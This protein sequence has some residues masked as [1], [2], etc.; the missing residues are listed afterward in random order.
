MT[1]LFS[2]EHYLAVAEAF[3]RGIERR[4]DAGLRPDVASVA[5]LFVSRWDAA[6]AQRRA[7]P[8]AQPARDRDRAGTYQAYRS[9]SASPRWQRIYNAGGRP[10]RLFWASTGSKDPDVSDVLY[11]GRSPHRSR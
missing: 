8:P 10:Q 1:L 2:R 7:R 4:I 6:V 3:L 5:S 9:L 11:I